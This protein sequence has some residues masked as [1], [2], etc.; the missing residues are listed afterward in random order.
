MRLV[1]DALVWPGF[2]LVVGRA[3]QIEA[4]EHRRAHGVERKAALVIGVDQLFVGRR[5]LQENAHPAER[6]FAV[7]DR[8]HARRDARPADA[9]EAVTAADEIASDLL[10][11]T[12]MTE[13]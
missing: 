7:V 5:R 10:I 1:P 3:L 12:A 6:I 8:Q 11:A 2:D 13:A 4:G 9:M